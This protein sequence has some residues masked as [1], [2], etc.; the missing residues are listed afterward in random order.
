MSRNDDDQGRT[1]R[2]ERE[3]QDLSTQIAYL[4]EELALAR[5]KL[6]ETPRHVRLLEERLAATQAQVEKMTEQNERLVATLKD[7]REQIV[8]LKEEIDRLAQPPSGYGVFLAAHDDGAVDVFTAGRKM[9]VALSPSIE[10]E[11]LRKG[12]EVL[13]NDALN[14]VDVLGFER[15]GEIVTLKELLESDEGVPD[16]ALVTSH[17][18]E[19][20]VVHLADTLSNAPLRAGDSLLVEP[21]AGY[22]YE[23]IQKSE[24]EEL[25]LEEVPDVDYESI[26]GLEGQIEMIRD[27]VELPFLHADL[28][29]EYQLRPPK[30]VLLYGPPGCGKTMIAKAVANSL[31]KKVA[32]ARGDDTSGDRA[33]S[34][35]LNIKGPELLNKY[36]GETERHIRLVFQRAREKASEGQPVIVFFDEMDSV[37]R[38][39]GS[40]VSS[41]V[42]NTI[43]PQL[44]SEID[45][46]EGLENVIVIGA[47][48][49]EDM[50]DPAILRPGRL[51]VKIKIERPDAE[52]ARDIFSKYITTDLPLNETDLAEQGD[53]RDGCV[54]DM[55]QR[56]VERMYTETEENRFLEVTYADGDKEVLYFKDFNSGAMIQNIVDRAKKMAIKEY[57]NTKTRG[58]RLQHLL[59]ACVDEFRENEDLP[60]TTNPDDWARISG[61]KGE[62]IVYIRTLVSG[63]G[64]ESGRS[65]D[66]VSNTGQYL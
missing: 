61:K 5:R 54:Q 66:T 58:L 53:S 63:K 1:N 36:V 32:E 23:R 10:P 19:E 40:G 57:L 22:A 28:F 25:V 12:Q 49:R 46:V 27:A 6:T 35:F 18:D 29:S 41:D 44:L 24:V 21:R 3:S 50:I 47:S 4:Q 34:Y 20:R 37:F 64:D 48:N 33:K 52:S 62:R 65:I 26:G 60:N 55:I 31:A 9:R 14:V 43:V 42:E 11:N 56:A 51:D 7:A 2:W 39:R 15:A 59:D 45:G 8:T 13:L 16:R 38:T 30:G 17:A